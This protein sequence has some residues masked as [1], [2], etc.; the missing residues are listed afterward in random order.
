MSTRVGT[1]GQVVIEK[2]IR[3]RLGVEP[4]CLAYQEVVGDRVVIR[5]VPAE[6]ERSLRG[7][8]AGERRRSV[9]PASWPAVVS[10][11]WRLSVAEERVD[12]YG[13]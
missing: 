2:G 8:L 5:F 1:K 13:E 12:E 10:D 9:D 4:G 11:A 3:D 6:H 7:T